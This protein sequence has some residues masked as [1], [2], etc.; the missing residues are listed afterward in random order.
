MSLQ[1][2]QDV[3]SHLLA[4]HNRGLG[5]TELNEGCGV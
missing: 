3:R 4:R 5:I 1:T 2:R